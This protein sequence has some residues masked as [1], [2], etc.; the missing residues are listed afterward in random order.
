MNDRIIFLVRRDIEFTPIML[1]RAISIALLE[2]LYEDIETRTLR[3]RVKERQWLES[4]LRTKIALYLESES[5]LLSTRMRLQEQSLN[6]V[7]VPNGDQLCLLAI[8]PCRKEEHNPVTKRFQLFRPKSSVRKKFEEAR[9][10]EVNL[11]LFVRTDLEIP[12]GKLIAQIGHAI[13]ALLLSPSFPIQEWVRQGFPLLVQE[14]ADEHSVMETKKLIEKFAPSSHLVID[15]GLTVFGSPT[16][17]IFSAV[18]FRSEAQNILSR[19]S[20]YMFSE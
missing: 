11:V 19:Y 1:A 14:V 6:F 10:E 7:S 17:T 2:L 20:H 16:T 4:S 3:A 15:Q 12:I 13:E 5:Q 18:L 8:G 9:I